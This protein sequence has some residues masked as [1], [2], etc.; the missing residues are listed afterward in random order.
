V[1][2]REREG[3]TLPFVFRSE[4]ASVL[5]VR[6]HVEPGS[7][8]YADEA[9]HWDTLHAHY[10]TKR[11]NHSQAYSTADACT[12]LAESFFSRVRRSEIGIHHHVAGPHLEAYASEMAW[13]E[14]HRRLD[15]GGLYG[16]AVDAVA[17]HPVSRIWKGYWQGSARNR[18][19]MF[20]GDSLRPPREPKPWYR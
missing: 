15:N 10:Q 4:D 5:T 13:R 12:N 7:T 14:D 9:S 11:I 8:I 6:Q 17:K 19:P 16:M 2:M 20:I 1:I 3:R 18:P